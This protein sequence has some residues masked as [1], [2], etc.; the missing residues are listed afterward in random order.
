MAPFRS[1]APSELSGLKAVGDGVSAALLDGAVVRVDARD[2]SAARARDDELTCL[3]ELEG[4]PHVLQCAAVVREDAAAGPVV[5]V[6]SAWPAGGT[7]R[8]LL[9]GGGGAEPPALA[10]AFALRVALGCARG[11]AALHTADWAHGALRSA[12]FALDER[13]EPQLAEL[14][15]VHRL[16]DG[17]AL[18]E[19]FA[20]R[21]DAAV[22]AAAA[23]QDGALALAPADAFLAPEVLAG[24]GGRAAAG[25]PRQRARTT[26]ALCAELC[27]SR[28]CARAPP[29]G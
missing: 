25:G 27:D 17:A 22:A 26:P 29:E 16:T 4:V 2:G 15:A 1:I 19:H 21:A 11:V 3:D 28:S 5:A 12:S 6:V 8:E 24:A 14:G 10:W 23:G 13:W 18:A 9:A 20:A 7:L